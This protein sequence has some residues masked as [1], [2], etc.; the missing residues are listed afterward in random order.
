[1]TVLQVTGEVFA[2]I[3]RTRCDQGSG[4][5]MLPFVNVALKHFTDKL[6]ALLDRMN[7]KEILTG[8]S[9]GL[10][11]WVSVETSSMETESGV[12]QFYSRPLD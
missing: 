3:L 10:C 6:I 8:G 7:M 11:I 2:K 4:R 12:C 9:L 5:L 1:M